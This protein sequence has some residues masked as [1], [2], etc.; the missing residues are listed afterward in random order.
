M[1]LPEPI[2]LATRTA[3]ALAL[4]EARDEVRWL[5]F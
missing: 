4:R 2:S 1:L 3:L 5:F